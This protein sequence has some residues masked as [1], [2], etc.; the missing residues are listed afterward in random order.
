MKVYGAII[1]VLFHGQEPVL[2]SG[3]IQ[4]NVIYGS[5][6][7]SKEN[8]EEVEKALE[9]ANALGFVRTFPEGIHT[10]VGE[11]GVML[12]AGQKQ[13]IAIARA[14]LKVLFSSLSHI[15]SVLVSESCSIQYR[16]QGS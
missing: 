2:M 5:Q 3:T 15:F 6:R 9:R 1:V 16:T 11:R 12:S 10:P 14:L 7:G 13:R 8:D 4:E